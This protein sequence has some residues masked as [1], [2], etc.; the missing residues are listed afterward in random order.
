MA[1]EY[2]KDENRPVY[3]APGR[4][5]PAGIYM[6]MFLERMAMSFNLLSACRLHLRYFCYYYYY[7]YL[8]RPKPSYYPSH[9]SESP[10]RS[11]ACE[12]QCGAHRLSRHNAARPSAGG[13]QIL[14]R[15]SYPSSLCPATKMVSAQPLTYAPWAPTA[16]G[17]NR[18]F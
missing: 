15:A 17:S 5:L 16:R 10:L 14:V 2:L 11:I 13:T 6:W 12:P 18:G 1:L 8:T 3:T 7:Y 4:R 9:R